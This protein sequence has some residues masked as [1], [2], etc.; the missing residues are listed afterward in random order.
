VV[1]WREVK[2]GGARGREGE[3]GEAREG[4]RGREGKEGEARE[5]ARA[6]VGGTEGGDT[7]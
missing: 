4:P 2:E 6:R 7:Q 5:E 3:E 1:S